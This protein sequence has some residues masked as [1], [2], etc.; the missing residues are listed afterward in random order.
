MTGAADLVVGSIV[1]PG[2]VVRAKSAPAASLA[3]FATAGMGASPSWNTFCVDDQIAFTG[4]FSVVGDL[5]LR[6]DPADLRDLGDGVSWAPATLCTQEGEPDPACTRTALGRTVSRLAADGYEALIGHEIEFQLFPLP[7]DGRWSAY[8]LRAMLDHRPFLDQLLT[9]ADAAGLEILQI[10]AEYAPGQFEISLAPRSPVVA[11]D[12]LVLAR[13]L[14][15]RAARAVGSDA[16]FSPLPVAAGSGNGAHQ[17]LSLLR[18]GSPLLSGGCG[19]HGLTAAG[20]AAIAGLLDALPGILAVLAGSILSGARMQPGM[21]SGVWRCWGRENRE[22]AVRLCTATAG[23]PRGASVE[24]KP[25]DVAANPYLASALLLEAA[26]TGIAERAAL[27]DEVPDNPATTTAVAERLPGGIPTLLTLLSGS[28]IAA[29][30]LGPDLL[31]AFQAVRRLE[32]AVFQDQP[33]EAVCERM[34]FAWTT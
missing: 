2:G 24:V 19:L 33:L 10:H 17:H 6:I 7:D 4:R 5:R 16:S 18:A 1:D 8:G 26:R 11:A 30:A 9:R 29:R 23:N 22:A 15:S 31:D 12:D 28:R 27:P 32:H 25:I 14:I 13:T 34:R 20:G 21:W 3:T